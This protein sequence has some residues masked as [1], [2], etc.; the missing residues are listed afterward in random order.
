MSLA[1][2]GAIS[3]ITGSTNNPCSPGKCKE[4]NLLDS[5]SS[6]LDSENTSLS[7]Y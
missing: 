7:S 2:T 1:A 3:S 4:V 5:A 6:D